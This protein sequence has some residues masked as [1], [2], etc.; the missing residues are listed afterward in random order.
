MRLALIVEIVKIVVS[1]QQTGNKKVLK[2]T[3]K[4]FNLSFLACNGLVCLVVILLLS[5]VLRILRPPSPSPFS[6]L[7]TSSK[8]RQ[9]WDHAVVVVDA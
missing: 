8:V 1:L 7:N 4:Y 3:H 2:K 5:W 6:M 9:L